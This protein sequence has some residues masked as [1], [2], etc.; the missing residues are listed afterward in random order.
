MMDV[1][2]D[3]RTSQRETLQVSKEILIELLGF[4]HIVLSS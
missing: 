2:T 4:R 1:R 3:R